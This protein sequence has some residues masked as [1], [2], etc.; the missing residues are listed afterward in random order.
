MLSY[1][2]EHSEGTHVDINILVSV[3]VIQICRHLMHVLSGTKDMEGLVSPGRKLM[4]GDI[5]QDGSKGTPPS[6]WPDI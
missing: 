2:L 4:S 1:Y 6:R 3:D 5:W